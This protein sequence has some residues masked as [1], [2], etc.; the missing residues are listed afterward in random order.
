MMT[1][2]DYEK[3]ADAFAATEPAFEDSPEYDIWQRTLKGIGIVLGNDNPRF[4][5]MRFSY[6]AS[7]GA[8][9]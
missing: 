9:R 2:Q 3:L 4:D 6:R 1:R 8:T 5:W 7:G